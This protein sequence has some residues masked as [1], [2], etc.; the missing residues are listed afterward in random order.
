MNIILS[1]LWYKYKIIRLRNWIPPIPYKGVPIGPSPFVKAYDSYTKDV[2]IGSWVS[3][4]IFI[5]QSD[6]GKHSKSGPS[7]LGEVDGC[8]RA[9]LRDARGNT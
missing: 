8:D 7:T 9:S 1:K 4:G 2:L 5:R 6:F 3:G